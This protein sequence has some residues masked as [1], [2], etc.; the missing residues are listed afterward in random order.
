MVKLKFCLACSGGGHLSELMQLE[1]FYK[2]KDHFF[3]TFKRPNSMQLSK[4]NKVYF[5]IDPKRNPFKLLINLVQ[6]AKIF[7]KEWPDAVIT[8]G[9]GVAFPV[10]LLAR[11]FGK[12]VVYIESFCR[13]DSPSL[14]GKFF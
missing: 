5:V 9:A 2:D 4:T 13:I 8:T 3:L 12:K 11:I 14:S 6:S 1:E 10:S 7:F